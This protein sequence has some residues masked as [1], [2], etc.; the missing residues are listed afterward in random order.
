[1][2]ATELRRIHAFWLKVLEAL[3]RLV[4]LGIFGSAH[5]LLDQ[6]LRMVFDPRMTKMVVFA[7]DVVSVLFLLVYIYLCWDMVTVFMPFLERIYKQ[8]TD[9]GK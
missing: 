4:A 5:Y 7:R 2:S 6:G 8:K 1:M 9:S 3:S